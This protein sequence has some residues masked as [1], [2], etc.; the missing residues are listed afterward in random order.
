MKNVL[1]TLVAV[2]LALGVTFAAAQRVVGA[3]KSTPSPAATNTGTPAPLPSAT[4]EGPDTAIPRL[5]AKIKD[6]PSDKDALQELAGYYLQVGKNDQSLALTQRLISLGVK[7]AQVYFLDGV[8]NQSLGRI[9]DATDDFEQATTQ[10][11][12]NAQILLTLTTLYLQTNR[13]S[14]AERVA[15]RAT[16]FNPSDK[17]VFENYGLVL[18]QEQKFDD[19]RTQFEI[20]AKLDPKDATPVVLEARSYVSQKAIALAEQ[21]FDRAL[22]IDPKSPDALLG[23]ASLQAGNHDVKGAIATFETLLGVETDDDSR[24]S[25][26]IQEYE[27][28]RDEKM[29]DEA[30]AALKRAEAAY[31][32]SA[33]VHLAYGDYDVSIGKDQAAGEAEW[34]QALGPARDNPQALDRLGELSMVQNKK[35]DALGYFKRLAEVVPNDAQVLGKLGQV[36][37][38]NNQ[39][40]DARTSFLQSFQLQHT[41]SA[42]AGLGQADLQLKNYKEC[43]QV[44]GA[45][46]KS[47]TDFFKQYPQDLYVYGKCAVA[48]SDKNT[49]RGA[50]TRFKAYVKPGSP[51]ANEVNK[52]LASLGSGGSSAPSPSPKPQHSPSSH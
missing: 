30:L 36:Q 42:L 13:A 23:K 16:T 49:A 46:D 50:F 3:P 52:M 8:A 41:P 40:A 10:E 12:T 25:V 26:I 15:K 1:R 11:P 18:G 27:V 20:A 39:F 21:D 32:N 48:V 34:K 51:L 35:S 17:R 31:P 6:N 14:D 28:Y 22:T 19:A 33:G 5:E 9:K 7:T 29:N 37:N 43:N 38:D 4:P 2:V 24:A 44:F 45:I 47:A